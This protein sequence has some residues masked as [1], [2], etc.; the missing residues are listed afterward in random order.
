MVTRR[1]EAAI[2]TVAASHIESDVLS[3]L[4]LEHRLAA[5]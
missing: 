1:F 4:S 2:T 5:L 3:G